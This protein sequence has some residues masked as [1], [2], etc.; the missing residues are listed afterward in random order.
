[1]R[2]AFEMRNSEGSGLP[3][4][5]AFLEHVTIYRN[6]LRTKGGLLLLIDTL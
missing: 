6:S 4:G 2:K 5:A 1:M 3:Y